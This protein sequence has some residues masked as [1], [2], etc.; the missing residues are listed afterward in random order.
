MTDIDPFDPG[1]AAL[2]FMSERHL[3]CLT[4]M[5]ADG[6][7][8][9][10]P[11]GFYFDADARVVRIITQR[12]SVK[13]RNAARGGRAAVTQFD[14]ARWLTLEGDVSLVTDTAG[15]A[16]AVQA[17]TL[18]YQAPRS[19]RAATRVGIEVRVDRMMGNA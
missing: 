17:Y 16:L 14:G 3:G 10:V 15:I 19:Q 6:S 13:A 1:H 12:T 8:H 4:T 2:A 5:R 18:R 7:P 9:V 11:V